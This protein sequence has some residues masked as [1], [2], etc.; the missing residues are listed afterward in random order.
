MR[1]VL[2]K[3]LLSAR[4]KVLPHHYDSDPATEPLALNRHVAAAF[5]CLD[6]H[7]GYGRYTHAGRHHC[8]NSCELSALKYNVR[9][10]PGLPAC[11]DHAVAK[12]VSFFQQKER[13]LLELVRLNCLPRRESVVI[14]MWAVGWD[15][16]RLAHIA[17]HLHAAGFDSV[18]TVALRWG[19]SYPGSSL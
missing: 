14:R 12:A 4:L 6:G 9:L 15:T 16:N 13:F 17:S 2:Q 8:Q 5:D 3:G 11:S 10:Q 18:R 7:L 19:Q 1:K